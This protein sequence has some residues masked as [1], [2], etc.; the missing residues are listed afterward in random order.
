MRS[1]RALIF[2]AVGAVVGW[3]TLSAILEAHASA[4]TPAPSSTEAVV[5]PAPAATTSET[6]AAPTTT[7]SAP[8]PAQSSENNS[9]ETHPAPHVYAPGELAGIPQ[10]EERKYV[11]SPRMR[12]MMERQTT[13]DLNVELGYG[14]LFRDPAKWEG[15]FRGGAGVLFVRDPLF[16]VLRFTYDYSPRSNATLGTELEANWVETGLWGNLGLMKDANS[17]Y[18][19]GRASVGFAIFGFE[20]EYRGDAS[21]QTYFALYGK[22]RIPLGII[23]QALR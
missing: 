7:D 20:G 3:G 19:G 5:S 17:R 16:W 12:K 10:G 2:I 9:T 1:S 4:Q 13:W 18:W 22:L 23:G 21:T 14:R 11:R 15:F 6:P 8:T